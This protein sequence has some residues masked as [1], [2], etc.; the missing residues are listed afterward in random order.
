[1][2]KIKIRAHYRAAIELLELMSI[3]SLIAL[4]AD[5]VWIIRDIWVTG[6]TPCLGFIATLLITASILMFIGVYKYHIKAVK[7]ILREILHAKVRK[8]QRL[9]KVTRRA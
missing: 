8:T 5:A 3:A 2:N 9:N 4:L 1:M 6:Y 7:Q